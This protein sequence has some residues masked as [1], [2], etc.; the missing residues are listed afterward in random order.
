[1]QHSLQ[2]SR[3]PAMLGLAIVGSLVIVGMVASSPS[4]A[5]DTATVPCTYNGATADVGARRPGNEARGQPRAEL[6][7]GHGEPGF[8]AQSAACR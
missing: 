7:S 5:A 2:R 4:R 3:L 6:R 1:M 8:P